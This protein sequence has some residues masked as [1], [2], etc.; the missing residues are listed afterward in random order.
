MS[1]PIFLVPEMTFLPA[2]IFF[3]SDNLDFNS[4]T[5]L[6]AAETANHSPVICPFS[7][8]TV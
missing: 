4:S 2:H 1:A 6:P 5:K 7:P 3:I 8:F